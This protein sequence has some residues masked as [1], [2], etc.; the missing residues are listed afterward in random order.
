MF[1]G[2]WVQDYKPAFQGWIC[3]EF[4]LRGGGI[5][6]KFWRGHDYL[7]QNGLCQ[8]KLPWSSFSRPGKVGIAS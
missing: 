1:S 3:R 5:K 4:S 2:M 8:V 6:I 7:N